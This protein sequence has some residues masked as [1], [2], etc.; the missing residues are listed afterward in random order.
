MKRTLPQS[1]QVDR[2]KLRKKIYQSSV[3]NL[4][5][6]KKRYQT[7]LTELTNTHQV[8][9]P[10]AKKI[11]QSEASDPVKMK[12]LS[13]ILF[14]DSE[15]TDDISDEDFSYT[16]NQELGKQIE[17]TISAY[18]VCPICGSK[19]Y[20][21]SDPTMPVYD[22]ICSNVKFHIENQTCFLFQVKTTHS[23]EFKYGIQVG[24]RFWGKTAHDANC[25]SAL[26][27]KFMV[28]GYILLF[29]DDKKI[30]KKKSLVLIPNYKKI[31]K[32]DQNFFYYG[33]ENSFGKKPL[34]WNPDLVDQYE[35]NS[36]FGKKRSINLVEDSAFSYED[37]ENPCKRQKLIFT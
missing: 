12:E 9:S 35:L 22:L 15:V 27:E 2:H 19:M 5:L 20:S 34:R 30:N 6:E 11:L 17:N 7:P 10:Q 36:I 37:K 14:T 23:S 4:I 3:S 1:P 29:V 21:F 33:K 32:S 31:I 28:C 13:K 24:S 8:L 25:L 26:D 16:N 18:C